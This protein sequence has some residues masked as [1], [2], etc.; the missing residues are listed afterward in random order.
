MYLDLPCPSAGK[1]HSHQVWRLWKGRPPPCFAPSLP[2]WDSCVLCEDICLQPFLGTEEICQ[3]QS[4]RKGTEGLLVTQSG[5]VPIW[6]EKKSGILNHSKCLYL[7][8][9]SPQPE[10][11][12]PTLPACAFNWP[13]STLGS[14]AANSP[15]F[16]PSTVS[17]LLGPISKDTPLKI[18]GS[19]YSIAPG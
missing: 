12:H 6:E 4:S 16:L 18:V 7:W 5:S 8:G 9:L 11:T 13:S 17:Y 14:P 2:C 10:A 1:T 3:V 19:F 15:I